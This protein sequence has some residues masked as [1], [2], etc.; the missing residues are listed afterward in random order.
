[1]R[2]KESHREE[3]VPAA[4]EVATPRGATSAE[5]YRLD[6]TKAHAGMK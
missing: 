4:T 1:M 2:A 6:R 3:R 5:T